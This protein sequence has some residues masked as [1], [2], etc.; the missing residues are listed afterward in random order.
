MGLFVVA[1]VAALLFLTLRVSN[2]VSL[3][4]SSQAYR[5]TA[6]FDTIGAL[7]VGAAIKSAG[8]VVGQ[9]TAIGFDNKSYQAIVT[10]DLDRRF[11]F[12]KDTAATILTSGL[13][14]E[15]YIGLDPGGDPDMLATGDRITNTQSALVLENLIGQVLSSNAAE[16][17]R[18]SVSANS[19]ELN[20]TPKG[21]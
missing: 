21:K 13:L 8:F 19:A 5:V 7:K 6:E 12:S 9:V 14:G 17:K 20:T 2:F 11:Q 10:L 18:G 1:G 4:P 16:G 15:Q 3:T